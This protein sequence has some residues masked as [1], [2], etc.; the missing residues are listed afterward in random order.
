M[1]GQESLFHFFGGELYRLDFKFSSNN[2][3]LQQKI[4]SF[5]SGILIMGGVLAGLSALLPGIYPLIGMF[6]V[7][8]AVGLTSI[9]IV[10]RLTK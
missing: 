8:A 9:I 7:V 1:F 6:A 4:G 5:A 3:R 10:T 2:P